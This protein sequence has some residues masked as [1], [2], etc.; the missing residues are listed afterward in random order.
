MNGGIEGARPRPRLALVGSFDDDTLSR[1]KNLFPTVWWGEDFTDLKK[2]VDYREIDLVVIGTDVPVRLRDPMLPYLNNCHLICFS[3]DVSPLPGPNK[4]TVVRTAREATTTEEYEL[5]T[6]PLSFHRR[7]ELDLRSISSAKGWVQLELVDPTHSVNVGELKRFREAFESKAIVLNHHTGLP[8]ATIYWREHDNLAVAWL[9]Q[10]AFSQYEWV[11][12]LS[13]DWAES[14]KEGFPAFGDWTKSSEWM[15]PE[16]IT[17]VDRIS[18]LEE[19]K[20]KTVRQIDE[21]I[22][23]L[24]QELARVTL[25]ASEGRRRLLTA[26]NDDLVEEVKAVFSDIGF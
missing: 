22:G 1:F 2:Q 15:L 14:D 26:Q 23:R 17:L 5:P 10:T 6:M 25:A 8:L 16:E 3:A 19:Q 12:L 21:E 9:P 11:E 13:I 24:S 4:P 7:R 20:L 18:S